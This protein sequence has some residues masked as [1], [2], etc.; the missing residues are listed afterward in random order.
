MNGNADEHENGQFESL[1]EYLRDNR[2]FDFTGYKRSSLRRRVIKRMHEVAIDS[3]SDYVDYLEVH[4]EEFNFL[5]NTIL[6]NVT[7]FFRDLPAWEYLEREIIPR[8]LEHKGRGDP[9]RVWSAGCAT[10]EEA[11]T[12]A[13]LLAEAMGEEQFKQR[14]KIYATDVDEDALT[15]A[16]HGT[17]S[18]KAVEP[19]PP[20]LRDQ[21]FELNGST[22]TFRNDL[23]RSIIFGRHDLVQD[24]PI[25]RMDL[26]VCRNTLMYFNAETQ[27]RILA[28]LHFALR[29]NGVLFLGKA[30][31]LLTQ[32]S[33]F[34]PIELKY[35][36]FAKVPREDLRNR[37][38]VLAQAGDTEAGAQ[39]DSYV[40]LREGAFSE[41]STAQVVVDA[42][43]ILVLANEAAR[44]TFELAPR[45]LGRPFR[46]L[47]LSY[48][49]VELRSRIDKVLTEN[50]P[51]QI[52]NIERHLPD[53]L[54]QHLDVELRPITENGNRPIGVFISF[55]DVTEF[56]RLQED[57]QRSKQD[58]ETAYEELQSA[59]EELETTNEE[60]QSTVEELQ[61]T[62]EE[63]QSSNEEMETMNEELHSVN[64]ELE[65]RNRDLMDN[66]AELQQAKAF[67]DSILASIRTGVAV[68]DNDFKILLWNEKAEDM[69]GL[70]A[71]EAE[72]RSLLNLDIG[73][74]VERLKEPIKEFIAGKE[75]SIE[76]EFDA[77]N[78]RGRSIRVRVT[79][80]VRI[81]TDSKRLGAVILMEEIT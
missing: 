37:M 30:E 58:L 74:P 55:E 76:M 9:V 80:T 19:V 64:E 11:Y 40:R 70:R 41:S 18:E 45:D 2:G 36:I 69:W 52:Q 49:P 20:P 71:G 29:G 24:A 43:G 14:V 39:L 65:A 44:K 16:R 79:T 54:V 28:R 78:R 6:I 3:F 8:I 48:R 4:P 15:K 10:G 72:G 31:M 42:N 38:V 56:Y 7:A 35:R 17:F 32:S 50:K 34:T 81:T 57:L 46:D 66:R 25:S 67:L 53:D 12:L 5:F 21:Y 63:L 75:E 51:V 59:N 68:I 13:I 33:L 22:Y 27:Q 62:N 60:L 61:T 23:R 1:L 26:I 77:V 73:L 47:E